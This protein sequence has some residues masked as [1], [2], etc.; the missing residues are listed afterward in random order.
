MKTY[1]VK[2]VIDVEAETALE[3]AKEAFRHMQE[4]GTTANVFGVKEHGKYKPTVTVDLQQ[5]L[6]LS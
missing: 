4:P 5:E 3:A 1:Q 2:W 6:A